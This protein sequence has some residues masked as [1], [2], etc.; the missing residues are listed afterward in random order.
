MAR[1]C[2]LFS[3]SSGNS[4]YFGTANG[5]ILVDVGVSA[6]RINT[7]LCDRGID[8]DGLQGIFITHEH[9][10]HISGLRV[11]LKQHPMPVYA[12]AGTA[13]ALLEKGALPP[14]APLTVIDGNALTVGDLTVQAFLTPH[15]SAQSCGYR[16]TFPDERTAVLATDMGYVTETVAKALC[17]AD[18]VH[19]ESNHD[20]RMLECGP[21]PYSLKCR[22]LGNGGHLSNEACA[23]LL[24]MLLQHGTTRVVLSHLSCENNTPDL[25]KATA[26]SHLQA[27]GAM[28][29]RDYQLWVAAPVGDT[30]PL[31]F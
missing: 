19:I 29:E 1:Y 26:T 15:D 17:G 13:R 25:A 22:V 30:A 31:I 2:S 16:V 10:D 28:A 18:L 8:P 6:K 7:A 21:Y 5:G 23:T 20:V 27:A 12:T 3:G 11:F 4:T 14:D 9:T 24:P